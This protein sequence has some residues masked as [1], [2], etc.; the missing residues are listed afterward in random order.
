MVLT[1]SMQG[2]GNFVNTAVL[3]ILVVIYRVAIPNYKNKAYPYAP[4]RCCLSCTS[5]AAS[6]HKDDCFCSSSCMI[7]TQHLGQSWWLPLVHAHSY[8]FFWQADL[9]A[10]SISKCLDVMVGGDTYSYNQTIRVTHR[11]SPKL[12]ASDVI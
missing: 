2:V 9:V 6:H 8:I 10:K 1:F 3:C 4:H 5:C 7:S 11:I 12:A